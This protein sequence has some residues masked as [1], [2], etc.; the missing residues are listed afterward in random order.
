MGSNAVFYIPFGIALDSSNTL[1]VVDR[2]NYRIRAVSLT[3]ITL[4]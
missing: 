4:D 2:Y 3:G 1:F